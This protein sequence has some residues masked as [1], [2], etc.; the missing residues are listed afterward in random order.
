MFNFKKKTSI[1]KKI[2]FIEI[3]VVIS[4]IIIFSSIISTTNLFMKKEVFSGKLIRKYEINAG[5]YE[6]YLM[7]DI[8]DK[9][10]NILPY[11]NNDDFIESKHESFSMHAQLIEGNSYLFEIKGYRY[12]KIYPNVI[13]A[14]P[15]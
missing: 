9:F 12:Y 1:F 13:S 8:Q 15:Q 2:T 4:I 14:T 11:C 6:P 10:G 7:L 5:K 3:L